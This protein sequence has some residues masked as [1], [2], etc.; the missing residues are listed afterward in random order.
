M[1]GGGVIGCAVADR[2]VRN[3]HRVLL[4]E[5]DRVGDHA[6]GAAAGLL[7]PHSE[8]IYSEAHLS[9]VARSLEI[10]PD[11][12]ARLERD[13]GIPVE[14]REQETLR[15]AM[16]QDQEPALVAAATRLG[17]RWLSQADCRDL[18]PGIGEAV[19][20]GILLDEAQV[21]PPRL[22]RAL[23]RAAVAGGAEIAESTPV[24]GFEVEAGEVRAV[25]TADGRFT[26]DVY[27]LAAG[28]WSQQLGQS[29]G[30]DLGVRPM[31]GQ[32]V[33]LLPPRPVCRRI[34]T[35]GKLYLV[36]KPD[37]T[38]VAGS[39]EDQVGFDARSTVEGV[40]G[41]LEFARAALPGL[42]GAA[43]ERVWAALRPAAPGELPLIGPAPGV[44]NLVLA[45][46]H[47][48]IGILLAPVTAERVA[49]LI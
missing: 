3:R 45:T 32:L 11:L 39:T 46:G 42:G 27:V 28:P 5:R 26:A 34:L 23:A 20:G 10:Y 48:R 24:F 33:G 15:V 41:L 6:S 16:A 49:Q 7:S 18:E 2:L 29:A 19:R 12:A 1:V 13:T 14:Y 17:R 25:I 44:A 8:N 31:R 40:S 37:G 35:C 43:I 4:F 38:L 30:L 36:P 9:L 22:V 47:F 21:T